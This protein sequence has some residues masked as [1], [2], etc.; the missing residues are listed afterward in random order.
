MPKG[1]EDLEGEK[2]LRNLSKNRI[3]S[4]KVDFAST[5]EKRFL[6]LMFKEGFSTPIIF[7]FPMSSRI[8][9]AIHSLFV[10]FS[11]TA[12]FLDEKKRVVDIRHVLPFTPFI[13]PRAPARYLIELP[14]KMAEGVEVGD[15]LSF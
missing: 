6:G 1:R 14:E 15:I 7:I 5:P 4:K 9:N 8:R 3:I 11:F 13:I 10:F 12:I 2:L